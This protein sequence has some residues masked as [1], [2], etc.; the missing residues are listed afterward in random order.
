MRQLSDDIMY[1]ASENKKAS[2]FA[3]CIRLQQVKIKKEVYLRYA[4]DCSM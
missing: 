1:S 2:V 3:L 4:S